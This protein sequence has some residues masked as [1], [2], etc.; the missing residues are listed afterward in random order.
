MRKSNTKEIDTKNNFNAIVKWVVAAFFAI[1]P[2]FYFGK[3]VMNAGNTPARI[4]FL[5]FFSVLIFLCGQK[6]A[7]MGRLRLPGKLTAP[8]VVL[9]LVIFASAVF[10]PLKMQVFHTQIWSEEMLLSQWMAGIFML[11]CL[12]QLLDTDEL[13]HTAIISVAIGGGVAAVVGLLDFFVFQSFAVMSPIRLTGT[14]F[15]PMYAGNYLLICIPFSIG[16]A[17]ITKK[18]LYYY[19]TGLLALSVV[20]TNARAAWVALFIYAIYLIVY[21]AMKNRRIAISAIIAMAVVAGLIFAIP[22]T[23]Y[24]ITALIQGDNATRARMV[25]MRTAWNEFLARPIL[26]WGV[27]TAQQISPQFRPLSNSSESNNGNRR[28]PLDEDHSE[29]YPHNIILLILAE[30]GLIGLIVISWLKL[31]IINTVRKSGGMQDMVIFTGVGA[32]ITWGIA[33]L[34]SYDNAAITCLP[35]LAITLIALRTKDMKFVRLPHSTSRLLYAISIIIAITTL[36]A[37]DSNN[38]L[39]RAMVESSQ[40][41]SIAST[42]NTRSYLMAGDTISLL[43]SIPLPDNVVYTHIVGLLNMRYDFAP[44]EGSKESARVALL[45]AVDEGLKIYYRDWQLLRNGI[46]LNFRFNSPDKSIIYIKALKDFEPNS[47]QVRILEAEAFMLMNSFGVAEKPVQEALRIAPDSPGPYIE[48]G[49]LYYGLFRT[50]D[51]RGQKLLKMSEDAYRRG[52]NIDMSAFKTSNIID[53]CSVLVINKKYDEVAKYGKYLRGNEQ[54]T[55]ALRGEITRILALTG[56]NDASEYI[57]KKL[58]E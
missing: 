45:L 51:I 17:I 23:R 37:I 42:N 38:K 24:R 48:A 55:M 47:A 7:T 2:V 6:I 21:F 25:Y 12:Y 46:I 15:N 22:Q 16:A 1:L 13:I 39:N 35:W 32:L 53:F 26:G 43:Q 36:V 44:D 19:I 31:S 3:D 18:Q 41:N 29:S 40:I 4:L 14:F 34:F 5:F 52:T 20:F 56:K 10:S 9:M 28:I 58:D 49:K 11:F 57:F 54:A 33:N 50:G 30:L 27:D 8:L